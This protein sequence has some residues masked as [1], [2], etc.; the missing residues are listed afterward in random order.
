MWFPL[1]PRGRL[2]TAPP[3]TKPKSTYTPSIFP[4]LLR[5][6]LL[7]LRDSADAFPPLKSAVSGVVALWDIADRAR[8]SKSDAHAI[9]LRAK[10]ILDVIADAVPDGSA[11]P[12]PMLVGINRFTVYDRVELRFTTDHSALS[13]LADVG[14]SMETIAVTGGVSRVLRLNRNE[15]ILQNIK[16]QLDDAY[17]DF[18]VSPFSGIRY[19][20]V[21]YHS[22]SVNAPC[23]G[24][25]GEART[26]ARSNTP[27]CQD[28]GRGY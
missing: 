14:R 22:D 17:R 9:A 12:E 13:L 5:T 18:M 21:K 6:S 23:R 19:G 15:R 2:K 4:D 16:S 10:E 8:H 7:A 25:A 20:P 27:G 26:R 28:G 1:P 3:N 11:I 24:P